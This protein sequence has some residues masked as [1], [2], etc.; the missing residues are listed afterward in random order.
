M[1]A[2]KRLSQRL[3][4]FCMFGLIPLFA[5][6]AVVIIPF[7]MGAFMTLTNWSGLSGGFEFTGLRNYTT[8]LSDPTFW[9]SLLLTLK[10]VVFT[11]ILTNVL[12][13]G[14]A[15]LVTGGLK[16]QNFFRAGFFTPNLIGGVILGFIW[17]FIFLRV[18][19]YMGVALDLEIFSYSWLGDPK[20]AFWALVIVGVWQSSGYMMLIYIA[21]LMGIDKSILEAA[22]LDGASKWQQLLK[23]KIPLM[24]PAFTISLFL[25]LQR[26]F[27][28]YDTNLSLTRGGPFRSTELAAMH[29]YNEAFLYQ[30][31]GPGQAKAIILFLIVAIIAISQVSVMK[32]MEVES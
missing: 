17:Q 9:N 30:N 32:K 19:V 23:I 31:Y 2:E 5:F 10:Y 3:K 13:F 16:S 22:D 4:I 11:M 1:Y 21:G 29:V 8:A 27:V 20:K 7:A 24:A 15:L 28:V 18:I 14:I 12:A 6:S 26:S 25:T